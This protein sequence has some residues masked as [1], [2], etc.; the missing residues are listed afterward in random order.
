MDEQTETV[1][2][3]SGHPLSLAEA[4][5]ELVRVSARGVLATLIPEGGYPYASLVEFLPTHE[6]DVVLFLSR[7][8]EHQHYLAADP[9]ASVLI[10]SALGEEHVLARPRVTLVGRVEIVEDRAAFSDAYAALHPDSRGYTAFPDFQFY[11]L[12]VERVRYIAGFGQMGWIKGE[13]YRKASAGE[14]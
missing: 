7:L 1:A 8:S 14:Q 13:R 10:V 3:P 9:R 2:D 4:A 5:R 6:G 11:R 12:R